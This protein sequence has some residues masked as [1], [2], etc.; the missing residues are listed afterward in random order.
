MDNI[1]IG[2]I[3]LTP[4]FS[5][6]N[7]NFI[8]GKPIPVNIRAIMHVDEWELGSYGNNIRQILSVSR[9]MFLDNTNRFFSESV[10]QVNDLIS[11]VAATPE[12]DFNSVENRAKRAYVD[13]LA[14]AT[15]YPGKSADE[16][17]EIIFKNHGLEI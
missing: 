3:F 8:F 7:A 13:F 12:E 11:S 14:R 5:G 6:L 15:L 2:Y 17:L 9:I 16:A 10:D 1:K 4:V